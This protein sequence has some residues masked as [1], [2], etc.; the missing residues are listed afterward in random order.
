MEW[1]RSVLSSVVGADL[2]R[3]EERKQ[4]QQSQASQARPS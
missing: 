1:K 2:L 3:Y 4:L